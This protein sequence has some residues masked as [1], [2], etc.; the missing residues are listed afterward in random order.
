MLHLICLTR[1]WIHLWFSYF[2]Y[3]LFLQINFNQ[4]CLYCFSI[5]TLLEPTAS[6]SCTSL[7]FDM[8][9]T[10]F[11]LKRITVGLKLHPSRTT[12]SSFFCKQF[13]VKKIPWFVPPQT[14]PYIYLFEELCKSFLLVWQKVT[15]S[16][17][18]ILLSILIS[19]FVYFEKYMF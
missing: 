7:L 12:R 9:N 18:T 1:F 13:W 5:W 10:F 16:S 19:R 14:S 6:T 3:C 4:H 17:L 15:Y 2:R 8:R 11:R